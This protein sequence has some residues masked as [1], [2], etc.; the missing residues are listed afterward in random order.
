VP[1]D[2]IGRS[3][4]ME[5]GFL[6]SG[7]IGHPPSSHRSNPCGRTN[8]GKTCRPSG[9]QPLDAPLDPDEA[10]V[11][12]QEGGRQATHQPTSPPASSPFRACGQNVC[13]RRPMQLLTKR[14]GWRH[15][16]WR[17]R[18]AT[19]RWGPC[20][21]ASGGQQCNPQCIVQSTAGL[22]SLA[23]LSALLHCPLRPS[24][25]SRLRCGFFRRR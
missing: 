6:L 9:F 15:I 2:G 24:A 21:A 10:R 12:R 16:A 13:N 1:I 20:H 17:P 14:A 22:C 4:L 25:S 23:A 8:G 3:R 7:E 5:G 19:I 11:F 18:A